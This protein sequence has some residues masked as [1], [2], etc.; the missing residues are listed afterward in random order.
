MSYVMKIMSI[1]QSLNHS[2][3]FVDPETD[4]HI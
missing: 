1:I 3:N 2:T 4:V